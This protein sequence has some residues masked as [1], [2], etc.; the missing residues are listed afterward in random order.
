MAMCMALRSDRE[1]AGELPRAGPLDAHCCSCDADTA[2]WMTTASTMYDIFPRPWRR[3]A[4]TLGLLAMLASAPA[5]AHKAHSHGRAELD[6]VVDAQGVSL[7][8]QAP[9][10]DLLGFER[11]PRNDAERQRVQALAERLRA[12]DGV[13]VPD[14]QAG[15]TLREVDLQA[16]VLGLGTAADGD[17]AAEHAD[18]ELTASFQCDRPAALR[19]LDVRLFA[20]FQGLRTVEVQLAGPKG[21]GRSVLR[22]DSARLPLAA[23]RR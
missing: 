21:Q 5:A 16:P 14:A 7:R 18:L 10:H 15:C 1:G 4:I 6:V 9:L 8:L 17:H 12:A 23:S 2:N 13:F 19:H 20:L 22:P 11:A 3:Q